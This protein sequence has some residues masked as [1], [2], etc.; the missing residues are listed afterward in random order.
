MNAHLF[1]F[2]EFEL[3]LRSE[4]L[5]KS[6]VRVPLASQPLKL[7]A[8]LVQRAGDLVTRE[9]IQKELWTKGSVVDFDHVVNQYIRQLR[10]VLGDSRESP[11]FIETAPRRGYRFIAPV[12]AVTHDSP[13]LL[14]GH[15]ESADA[16]GVPIGPAPREPTPS[17]GDATLAAEAAAS[18][19]GGTAEGSTAATE[20]SDSA[21]AMWVSKSPTNGRRKY[22]MASMAAIAVVLVIVAAITLVRRGSPA[23]LPTYARNGGPVQARNEPSSPSGVGAQRSE[24]PPGSRVAEARAAYTKGKYFFNQSTVEGFQKSCEYF[25]QA[26]EADPANALAYN[27]MA[28]CYLALVA[29]GLVAADE[30][31]PK[32]KAMATKSIELDGSLA[33]GHV[34]L[35]ALLLNYE[36]NWPGAHAELDKAVH[37]DPA[38]LDGHFALS[39]YY[40]TVGQVDAAADELRKAQA[41][42]PT[43]EKSYLMLG[44]LYVWA[45]RFAESGEDLEKCVEISPYNAMAHFG[46]ALTYSHTG[47]N[48][49]AMTE[50]LQ[51]LAI[52]KETDIAAQVKRT[53]ESSGFAHAQRRYSELMAPALVKRGAFPYSI[54][55]E[56]A[57]LGENSRA[58][59]YL[60]QAYRDRSTLMTHL[61]V[62]SSLDNLRGEPRFKHLLEQ[63]KLTDEQLEASAQLAANH[64]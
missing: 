23:G 54:A 11:T 24:D 8:L 1:T 48:P 62:D 36:W 35:G 28:D 6:G 42:A 13:P 38:G 2:R 50:L 21:A 53:Y 31:M 9:E 40:R 63:M 37:L 45:G 61:K 20:N 47:R 4:L 18:S 34:A 7:L 51:Y 46:L 19:E 57:L 44:W 49:Q 56:Y 14:S 16:G 60:E 17:N 41:L 26:L 58:L 12:T 52:T 3:N 64:H 30:F 39:N 55:T 22:L 29:N 27:G 5:K 15:T 43:S 25:R 10:G 59:D 33:E 32:A